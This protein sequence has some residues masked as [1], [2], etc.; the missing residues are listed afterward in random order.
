M[1]VYVVLCPHAHMF[2][3][4]ANHIQNAVSHHFEAD[5]SLR[6]H[7]KSI[8]SIHSVCPPVVIPSGISRVGIQSYSHI[9]M[10]YPS[11]SWNAH[12]WPEIPRLEKTVSDI[13]YVSSFRVGSGK[14]DTFTT[15]FNIPPLLLV[16]LYH[17][18]LLLR[19]RGSHL[20]HSGGLPCFWDLY[21]FPDQNLKHLSKCRTAAGSK[22]NVRYYDI[23]EFNI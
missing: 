14:I 21:V 12:I 20:S 5:F 16:L 17:Y 11:R 19:L 13:K 15:G 2:T 22:L 23:Y 6:A 9:H 7:T 1:C 18:P 10:P 3:D 4:A 8:P